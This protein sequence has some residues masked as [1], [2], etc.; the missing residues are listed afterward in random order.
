MEG[1]SEEEGMPRLKES[2]LEKAARNYKAKTGVV[3]D[4]FH[5]KVPLDL[6]IETRGEVVEFME[7]VEQCGSGRNKFAQR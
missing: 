7:K 1:R 2:D 3:C 4:G 5:P 6:T